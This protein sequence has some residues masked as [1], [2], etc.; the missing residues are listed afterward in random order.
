VVD[1]CE[2]AHP[3]M[4][5]YKWHHPVLNYEV[6]VGKLQ[7]RRNLHI[8]QAPAVKYIVGKKIKAAMPAQY[9][10]TLT[11]GCCSGVNDSKNQCSFILIVFRYYSSV[12]CFY[13][14]P[15]EAKYHKGP[16]MRFIMVRSQ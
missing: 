10:L 7:D 11:L 4:V 1:H 6:S 5:S 9:K 15:I 2:S 12:Q 16:L 14:W 13:Q 8:P 3:K